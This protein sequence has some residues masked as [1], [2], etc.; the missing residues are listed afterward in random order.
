MNEEEQRVFND[1]TMRC[2]KTILKTLDNLDV[3]IK[4]MEDYLVILEK[5]RKERRMNG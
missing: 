5:E 2:L 1:T 4:R 3:R